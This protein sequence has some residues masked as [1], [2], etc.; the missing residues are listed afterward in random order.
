MHFQTVQGVI[1]AI[2]SAWYNGRQI[3]P[4]VGAGFSAEAGVPTTEGVVRYLAQLHGYVRDKA[5]LPFR[6]EEGEDGGSPASLP[7]LHHLLAPYD[8]VPLYVREHGWPNYYHLYQNYGNWLKLHR[9]RAS[10]G[11]EVARQLDRLTRELYPNLVAQIEEIL[12]DLEREPVDTFIPRVPSS[13]LWWCLGRWPD[14]VLHLA[15]GDLGFANGLFKRLQLGHRPGLSHRFLAFLARVLGTRMFLSTAADDLLERALVAE[16]L[17]HAVFV[18][19]AG[20]RWPSPELIRAGPAVIRMHGDPSD[21]VGSM[22][23]SA[24]DRSLRKDFLN[25]LPPGHPLFLVMGTSG[26]DRRVIDLVEWL[27]KHYRSAQDTSVIW[28]HYEPS[29]PRSITQLL[30]VGLGIEFARV[31]H[32]GMF[33]SHLYSALTSR[34]PSSHE[35]YLAHPQRP[36]GLEPR[37]SVPESVDAEADDERRVA[38]VRLY[39]RDN[40]FLFTNLPRDKEYVAIT[41]PNASERLAAFVNELPSHIPIW[42][43]LESQYTLAGVVGAIIDQ[44]RTFDQRLAPATLPLDE[45]GGQPELVKV[46][47]RPHEEVVQRGASRVLDALSRA[48]YVLAIDALECYTWPHTVHHGDTRRGPKTAA[49]RELL[50]RFLLDLIEGAGTLHG[51]LICISV[52]QSELRRFN[53][54]WPPAVDADLRRA[55]ERLIRAIVRAPHTAPDKIPCLAYFHPES[56]PAPNHELDPAAG[57][58]AGVV[59]EPS[60]GEPDKDAGFEWTSAGCAQLALHCLSCFRRTRNLV[61]LHT[62]LLYLVKDPSGSGPGGPD[63]DQ[64]RLRSA[65][66]EPYRKV[67]GA[68]AWFEKQEYLKPVAGGGRWMSRLLRDRIYSANSRYTENRHIQALVKDL[69][70]AKGLHDAGREPMIQGLVRTT[71]Q[72]LLLSIHHDRIARYYYFHNYIQSQDPFAFFEYVYHC[73]SSIRYLSKLLLVR[74]I[75]GEMDPVAWGAVSERCVNALKLFPMDHFYIKKVE[76]VGSLLRPDGIQGALQK[77]RKREIRGLR[78]AWKRSR[79]SLLRTVPAEQIISWCR[80]LIEDDLPQFCA[81]KY[82]RRVGRGGVRPVDLGDLDPPAVRAEVRWLRLDLFDLWAQ[83]YR[84]RADYVQ[85]VKLRLRQLIHSNSRSR[86]AMRASEEPSRFLLDMVKD[87]Y[88]NIEGGRLDDVLKEFGP[89]LPP[90]NRPRGGLLVRFRR[91]CTW[92][93][94]IAECL[95]ARE[96]QAAFEG[97]PRTGLTGRLLD[98]IEELLDS[99]SFGDRGEGPRSIDA[100][101]FRCRLLGIE[102]GLGVLNFWRP[103]YLFKGRQARR[104]GGDLYAGCREALIDLRR[105]DAA[106]G[107]AYFEYRTRFL[108]ARAR[109]NALRSLSGLPDGPLPASIGEERAAAGPADDATSAEDLVP[110]SIVDSYR[111]LELARG[112]PRGGSQLLHHARADL[113]GAELALIEADELLV[114]KAGLRDRQALRHADELRLLLRQ[115]AAKHGVARGYLRRVA[116]QLMAGRRNTVWWKFHY[117]VEAQYYSERVL[118]MLAELYSEGTRGGDAGPTRLEPDRAR[119][120]LT[121][122]LRRL[123]QGLIAIRRGIDRGLNRQSHD[124]TEVEPWLRQIWRELFFCSLM[125]VAKVEAHDPWLEKGGRFDADLAHAWCALNRSAGLLAESEVEPLWERG[126]EKMDGVRAQLPD[127]GAGVRMG[128][129]IRYAVTQAASTIPCSSP[130]PLL[131]STRESGA[132]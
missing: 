48:Q 69:G 9:S 115:A 63:G 124:P 47:A 54:P 60:G 104:T 57:D 130:R 125:Y 8:E 62:I 96:E 126:L 107:L 80:W 1:K 101:R 94:D 16:G 11:E 45:E 79:D 73:T 14:L 36:I 2:R 37:H 100:L 127:G 3:V 44:C 49:R 33:L 99:P 77:R 39:Y 35:P 122:L 105:Y 128:L 19:G 29:P 13:A 40:C 24:L 27:L 108:I 68:L 87:Q 82:A 71:L 55:K 91:A 6:H 10:L 106:E 116:G 41:A 50:L 21:P 95:S 46:G 103:G 76:V 114:A 98:R 23:Y 132:W 74:E 83:C 88:N 70:Q 129:I 53:T 5:Y 61:A 52:G 119:Q 42:I 26:R 102:H 118:M 109:A 20:R 89:S 85:C 111:D 59:V 15:S 67:D 93:L 43:D 75:A 28:L 131:V 120:K 78:L 66:Q 90:L 64:D 65:P 86:K 31:T 32:P 22:M 34:H 92:W 38:P 97:E 4:L 121:D 113:Y 81:D 117:Q 110:A 84:D 112:G 25:S 30:N 56:P 51:S 12:P 18:L 7:T 72:C 123:R 17:E 58:L